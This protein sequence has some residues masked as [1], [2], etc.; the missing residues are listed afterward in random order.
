[1]E[2]PARFNSPGWLQQARQSPAHLSPCT[3]GQGQKDATL[4][5]GR[6]VEP[7]S[8]STWHE[9]AESRQ[10]SHRFPAPHQA[11]GTVG[12]TEDKGCRSSRREEQAGA[13][14]VTQR[15]KAAVGTSPQLNSK[16]HCHK[17]Q[18]SQR[19][20]NPNRARSRANTTPSKPQPQPS[21]RQRPRE[22]LTNTSATAEAACGSLRA[23]GTSQPSALQTG[24]PLPPPASHQ[25]S[26][27]RTP[28]GP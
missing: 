15:A 18:Q 6:E 1:M 21:R 7:G 19:R 22:I 2:L 12:R 23:A 8:S 27:R 25:H 26:L 3:S 11:A 10:S 5:A 17:S 4:P 28:P 9:P 16:E 14:G 13:P 24:Q 20:Q